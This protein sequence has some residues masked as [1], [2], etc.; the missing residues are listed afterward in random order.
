MIRYAR[1][2]AS[3]AVVVAVSSR[4]RAGEPSTAALADFED[5]RR[6]EQAGDYAAAIARFQESE[7]LA[8]SVGTELNLGSCFEQEGRFASA[9]RMYQ[10]GADRAEASG[11]TKRA[12]G[13]KKRA[14]A[15]AERASSLQIEVEDPASDLELFL[16]DERVDPKMWSTPQ[17]IDGGPHRVRCVAPG[18]APWS[19]EV[20][21]GPERDRARV[22]VSRLESLAVEPE[23]IPVAKPEAGPVGGSPPPVP[24]QG[25]AAFPAPNWSV[26]RIVGAATASV[27]VVGIAIGAYS[28][29]EAISQ[30]NRRQAAC[31]KN[32]CNEAGDAYGQDAKTSAAV[33]TVGFIAGGV[34][35]A[36]G[37]ALFV[38]AAP[39]KSATSVRVGI[40]PVRGGTV[41]GAA[42]TF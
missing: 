7:R 28:G 40:A 9:A 3:I 25:A 39:R 17:P 26:S 13:A 19:A 27:G 32:V 2:L 14:A 34:A 5:G 35:L 21:I 20:T 8:P 30:W 4:V 11:E 12:T 24:V 41:I 33:A 1:V 31:P 6:L 37:V 29:L 23:P 38:L 22:A 42:G 36:A 15:I 10:Q 16:D 18:R